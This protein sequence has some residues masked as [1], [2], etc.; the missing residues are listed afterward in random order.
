MLERTALS[1]TELLAEAVA[2]SDVYAQTKDIRLGLSVEE[3]LTVEGDSRLLRSAVTNLLRNAVKFT[4]HGSVMIRA[5]RDGML[6]RVEV[7][8]CCGGLPEGKLA[9][10]FQPFVQVGGDRSRLWSRAGDHPPGGA[11]ARRPRS[12]WPTCRARAASSALRCRWSPR[13]PGHKSPSRAT[14]KRLP[15]YRP[16]DL[17]AAT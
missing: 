5:R 11:R 13:R 14:L 9:S 12:S 2:E 4:S 1:L 8:D 7:E 6:A 10:L 17:R 15:D 16:E 3:G